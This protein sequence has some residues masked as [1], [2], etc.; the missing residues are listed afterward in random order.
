M[1]VAFR[2]N[3]G[4]SEGFGHLS[5]CM[6][7][8]RAFNRAG[9][10]A[11][12]F[13]NKPP[14]VSEAPILRGLNPDEIA[15]IY[16]GEQQVLEK[17][18]TS[19]SSRADAWRTRA[20]CA[21]HKCD[22]VVLDTYS[23]SDAWMSGWSDYLPSVSVSDF[24]APEGVTT[25]LDYG[26]DAS[27]AKHSNHGGKVRDV[28]TGPDF[29]L[30]SEDFARFDC[31]P[32]YESFLT[33]L[34]LVTLGAAT[35]GSISSF[36]MSILLELFQHAKV[37]VPESL[38]LPSGGSKETRARILQRKQSKSLADFFEL[39]DFAVV[40]GGVSMYELLASGKPGL[41]LL[42]AENQRL[43]LKAALKGEILRGGELSDLQS[44]AEG[45]KAELNLQISSPIVNWLRSRSIVDHLGPD[46]VVFALNGMTGRREALRE[47][48]DSDLPFLLRL[49]NNPTTRNF[50]FRNQLISASEHLAWFRSGK[51]MG[52]RKIWIFEVD[53]LA[54]GQCRIDQVDD[55]WSLDFS[56]LEAFRGKGYGTAMLRKLLECVDTPSKI[57]ALVKADNPGSSSTLEKVGFHLS[58]NQMRVLKYEWSN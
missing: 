40:G 16:I 32:T 57:I 44:L 31:A 30:V 20:Y 37:L 45:L 13:S 4:G 8:A 9:H 17:T 50:A 52:R 12:I 49:A 24:P 55:E 47:A 48:R 7:L 6:A 21:K 15:I 11:I 34:C 33:S 3:F 51:M 2:L 27:L 22:L 35:P 56:V 10:Q 58:S 18:V 54:I 43:A 14:A 25:V 5:R 26:F 53:G 46:R 41:A 29:A 28:L 19:E 38:I 36:V 42:T 1:R 39:A 23:L